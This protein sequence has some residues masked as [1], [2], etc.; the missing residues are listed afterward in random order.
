M[1]AIPVLINVACAAADLGLAYLTYKNLRKFC[2]K[3]SKDLKPP[4]P[5]RDLM[6]PPQ[7]SSLGLSSPIIS[8]SV[9]PPVAYIS[10]FEYDLLRYGDTYQF[11]SCGWY[12][13]PSSWFDSVI[14]GWYISEDAWATSASEFYIGPYASGKIAVTQ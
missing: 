11:N 4:P 13:T 5:F 9:Q 8:Q 12:Y 1:S 10:Q 14:V 7:T 3:S 6:D 2:N